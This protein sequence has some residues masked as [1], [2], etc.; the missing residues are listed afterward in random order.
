LGSGVDVECKVCLDQYEL[1][2]VDGSVV[3]CS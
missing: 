1:T 3:P 2:G